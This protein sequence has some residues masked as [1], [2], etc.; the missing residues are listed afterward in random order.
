MNYYSNY[1]SS[2]APRFYK[3][4]TLFNEYKKEEDFFLNP[5]NY[6]RIERGNLNQLNEALNLLKNSNKN[7]RL[8]EYGDEEDEE[9]LNK[10]FFYCCQ[11][12]ETDEKEEFCNH[13]NYYSIPLFKLHE[14]IKKDKNLKITNDFL[15]SD[16]HHNYINIPSVCSPINEIFCNGK[17]YFLGLEKSYF[18]D[19]IKLRRI[20]GFHYYKSMSYQYGDIFQFFKEDIRKEVINNIKKDLIL[21]PQ[22]LDC[23]E[24]D[25]REYNRIMN[26]YNPLYKTLEGDELTDKIK[27]YGVDKCYSMIRH[28]NI[29]LV[30]K[31]MLEDE[32]LF[33]FQNDKFIYENLKDKDFK[34][35]KYIKKMSFHKAY[36]Q[37]IY[38]YIN[39]SYNIPQIILSINK[40]KRLFLKCYY[41]PRHPIG[42]RRLNKSYDLLFNE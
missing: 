3:D 20:C 13:L 27:I 26:L 11:W 22:F 16:L 17:Y 14:D 34:I 36:R 42:I 41:D 32:K 19:R 28:F 31:L 9:E 29:K 4:M 8:L 35:I 10:N 24:L 5:L 2:I 33:Y 18:S 6:L 39:Y 12:C 30:F 15:R 21:R 38:N 23:E 1:C 40:I 7:F 37:N 25:K